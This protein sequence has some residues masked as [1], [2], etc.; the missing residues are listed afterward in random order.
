MRVGV[1]SGIERA[2]PSGE[3]PF[4]CADMAQSRQAS[5]QKGGRGSDSGREDCWR[6]V[7]PPEN[8]L[9]KW[10]PLATQ[11]APFSAPSSLCLAG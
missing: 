4:S 2:V 5:R 7:P 8:F 9:R 1:R 11:P 3:R 10:P 6:R